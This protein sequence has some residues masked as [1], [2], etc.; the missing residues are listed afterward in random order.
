MT[1]ITTATWLASAAAGIAAT[2]AVY[3]GALALGRRTNNHPLANPVLLSMSAIASLLLVAD[4]DYVDYA[5]ATAPLTFLLGTATVALAVPLHAQLAQLRA[6]ALRLS[7]AMLA[8]SVLAL[9]SAVLIADWLG[10]STDTLRSLAPKSATTPVAMAIVERSGGLPSL[11]A[12]I[13]VVTGIF[14]AVLGPGLLRR[15]GVTEPAAV[16]LALGVA[17]HGIGTARAFQ[18][19]PTAGS[20]AGLA[21]GINALLTTVLV[22]L[23]WWLWG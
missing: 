2:V 19:H 23:F 7:L 13:V 8:G 3:A 14:G 4:F 15:A 10:A 9:I 6:S 1:A 16:G 22:P 11:A 18:A 20:Y 17:A 21:M 5:D 12:V